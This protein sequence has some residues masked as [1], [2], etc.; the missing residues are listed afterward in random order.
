M[1]SDKYEGLS[2][3][4]KDEEAQQVFKISSEVIQMC[5]THKGMES[6]F[7]DLESEVKRVIKS[8]ISYDKLDDNLKKVA[9]Y[10]LSYVSKLI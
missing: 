1:E 3:I 5:L 6:E 8:Q 10:Y 2:K 9:D 4:L 7:D